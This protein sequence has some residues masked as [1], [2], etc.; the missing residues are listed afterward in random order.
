MKAEGVASSE[1]EQCSD[2]DDG[3]QSEDSFSDNEFDHEQEYEPEE[4][5]VDLKDL[6]NGT[7][8]AFKYKIYSL[9][10]VFSSELKQDAECFICLERFKKNYTELLELGCGHPLH[11]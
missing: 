2:Y 6:L 11:M 7:D 10:K 3:I 4:V 9:K 5:K 1:W 8:Q